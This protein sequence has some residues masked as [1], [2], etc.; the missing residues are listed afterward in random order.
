MR[1]ARAEQIARNIA[2]QVEDGHLVPGTRIGSVRG[3]AEEF[4]VS[5]NTMVEAYDRLVASGAISNRK[6]GS[7]FYI[8]RPRPKAAATTTGACRSGH[9]PCCRCCASSSN[10]HH[11]VRVGDG[12]PPA[13]WMEGSELGRHLQRQRP[14]SA[15]ATHGSRL[16]HAA[17]LRAAARDHRPACSIE[18]SIHATADGRPADLR[19]QSRARP[20]SCAISSNRATPCCVDSPGYYPLFGKLRLMRADAGRRC[21]QHCRGPRP[22]RFRGQGACSIGRSSSSPRRSPHNPT[23]TSMALGQPPPP[24]SGRPSVTA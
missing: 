1:I 12:R 4:G 18:R 11:A 19:R 15:A 2:K 5:K 17:R 9:R 6:R 22:R 13:S 14:A 20:A 21:A 3:A 10:Q 24:A 16:R 7:G 8:C 23:G